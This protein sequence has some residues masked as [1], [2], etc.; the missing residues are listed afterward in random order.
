MSEARGLTAG[1]ALPWDGTALPNAVML[2]Q[3]AV[4]HRPPHRTCAAAAM[5]P[6]QVGDGVILS[7]SS[8]L[9]LQLTRRFFQRLTG[10]VF[11]VLRAANQMSPSK[12]PRRQ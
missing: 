6:L 3:N 5:P 7:G 12:Q 11:R 9:A 10:D 2:V 1:L 4:W 8:L